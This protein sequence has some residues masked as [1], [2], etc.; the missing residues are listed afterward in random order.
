M[1]CEIR[2]NVTKEERH[3]NPEVS[4]Y[5]DYG[6]GSCRVSQE[7]QVDGTWEFESHPNL[8]AYAVSI[9]GD[10]SHLDLL[11]DKV[12]FDP[13]WDFEIDYRSVEIEIYGNDKEWYKQALNLHDGR[14]YNEP[15]KALQKMAKWDESDIDSE[16]ATEIAERFSTMEVS[17]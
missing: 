6:S 13:E 17:E 8:D 1:I 16:R 9:H 4:E 15:E 10:R 11:L 7:L 5:H 12:G 3:K 14:W 2:L